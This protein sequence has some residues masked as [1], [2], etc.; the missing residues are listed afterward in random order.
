MS[1]VLGLTQSGF[2]PASRFRWVQFMPHL[3]RSG[4]EVTHWPNRPDRQWS[5]R[6]PLRS[7]RFLHYQWGRLRMKVN[8][9]ADVGAARRFDVVFVNR[10]L[11]GRG[12]FLERRLLR[13]NPCVVFDFDDAIFVGPNEPDVAW[14]CEHA[15]WVTPGNGYLEAFARR[16]TERVTIIP[17]VIDTD[18]YQVRRY[19]DGAAGSRVRVGWSGSDQSIHPTLVPR[20]PMLRKLQEKLDFELVVICN[21]KPKLDMAGLNWS[22]VPWKAD[23]EAKLAEKFDIGIMPLSDDRFQKGKCGLKLLQYMAAG[24]PTIASPVGVNEAIVQPGVTG[25]AARTDDEWFEALAA[26][27]GDG[28]HRATLG[29]AGR[30][31]CEEEYSVRRWLPVLVDIFE[32]VRGISK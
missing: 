8:R 1:S 29:T 17:T 16:F 10:D 26:L 25:Y 32:K 23:D 14:M 3:V 4:W 19:C 15:A 24:L 28:S 31:R 27:I 20:L 12:T 7:A 2:D 13:C 30:R 18:A 6:L 9:W 21:T 5:S 11:A 22:F